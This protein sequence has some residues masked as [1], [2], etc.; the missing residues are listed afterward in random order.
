MPQ[1]LP[2]DLGPALPGDETWQFAVEG[3]SGRRLRVEESWLSVAD[4]TTGIRGSL[5]ENGEAGDPFVLASGVYGD[6]QTLV[7][8]PSWASLGRC[9][10][11]PGR[12]PGARPA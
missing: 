3:G 1:T 9:R 8:V 12:S 6:S 10:R 11:S 5:E 7:E 4:G 2:G